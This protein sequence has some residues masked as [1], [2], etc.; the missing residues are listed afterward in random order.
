MNAETLAALQGSIKHWEENVERVKN[1]NHPILGA[2][3]CP[4]CDMFK[5]KGNECNCCPVKLLTGKHL[6][7]STPYCDVTKNIGTKLLAACEAEL[8][9]LRSLLPEEVKS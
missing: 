9:F 2:E 6:C 1:D 4:L 8:A 7:I 3:H 5:R